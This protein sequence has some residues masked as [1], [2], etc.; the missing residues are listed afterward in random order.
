MI[1]PGLAGQILSTLGGSL[2]CTV[3]YLVKSH[4]PQGQVVCR[5]LHQSYRPAFLGLSAWVISILDPVLRALPLLVHDSQQFKGRVHNMPVPYGAKLVCVDVKDFFLS[6]SSIELAD[7]VSSL[8]SGALASM[9]REVL[10]FL[11]EH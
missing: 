8:F 7:L 9:M 11:L 5:T 10:Y 2:G 3:G 6:G 4:K 1:R